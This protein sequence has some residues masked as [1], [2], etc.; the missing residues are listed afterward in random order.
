MGVVALEPA[1]LDPR[2]YWV[3]V[4]PGSLSVW[5]EHW[6][7]R[8]HRDLLT[9]VL[10]E[11]LA[12]APSANY[13]RDSGDVDVLANK[14]EEEQHQS[15]ASWLKELKKNRRD[16]FRPWAWWRGFSQSLSH[17]RHPS[18]YMSL[19]DGYRGTAHHH[20]YSREWESDSGPSHHS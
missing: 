4:E 14:E 20:H 13:W 10:P 12:V 11:T 5:T 18:L 16:R 6:E 2:P 1:S 17:S 3:F 9:C 15:S 8:A 19:M 7:I